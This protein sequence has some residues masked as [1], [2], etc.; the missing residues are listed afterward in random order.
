[1][2]E[3]DFALDL[4]SELLGKARAAGADAAD[5]V[6]VESAAISTSW[7]LGQPE[8]VER[9]EGNDVGLRVFVGRSQAVVSSTDIRPQ[10]LDEL[11]GRAVAMARAVP[12]DPYCGL[13]EPEMLA[14]DVP[15][16]DLCDPHDPSA[17]DLTAMTAAAED[18]ARAVPG[19]TNSDGAEASWSRSRIT[20]ATSNGFAG[21]YP[22]SQFAISASVVAGEGTQMER[23]Y[24]YAITRYRK[25][26]EAPEEIGRR[27]GERAVKRLNP[28]RMKSCQVPIVFDP[29][30]SNGFLRL[31]A[32][33]IA[34]PA[35]ARGTS[36]LKGRLGKSVFAPGI[37][38]VD[39]PRR[40][41]GLASKPFDGEG[42]ATLRR[43]VIEDGHL[44]TW[45]LDSRSARQLNLPTTGHA[46]RGTSSPPAPAP[47]NL[48]MEPGDTTP[49]DMIGAV[50]N[51]FY[52]TEMMGMSFN[53]V[54][55]DYSRGAAGFWIENGALAYPVSG[56]TVAGN[57]L[58]MFPK[59]T[60]ADDLA[61]RYG[62]NAPTLRIDGMTVAGT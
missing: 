62:I 20:L 18:A 51:G 45:L 23:D 7:R 25:T 42:V 19:V 48:Y 17:E 54:T 1:M 28:R 34:G 29:R 50:E 26:L 2:P 57:L 41:R 56:L 47:T 21:S 33:S 8:D 39:D 49:E 5:A 35:I 22:T 60:P 13:A 4:L 55:G 58:E 9:A 40:P 15:D 61:F 16:L 3:S 46:A 30:V 44:I 37:T 6:M 38:V 32:G 10:A 12:E 43:T 14:T 31:L 59:T 36:F 24:E 52:V 11:T 27:A 53:N